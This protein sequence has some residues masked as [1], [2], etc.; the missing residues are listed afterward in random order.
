MPPREVWNW[1]EG[2]VSTRAWYVATFVPPQL[3]R[4]A[5]RICWA[6]EL[7]VRYGDRKEVRQNLHANFSTASWW[8]PETSYF[9]TKKQMLEDFRSHETDANVLLW[10]DEFIETLSSRIESARIREERG[11]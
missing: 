8:G 3:E 9:A 6:R 11:F 2:D 4:S 1:I 7:L 5:E 10:L